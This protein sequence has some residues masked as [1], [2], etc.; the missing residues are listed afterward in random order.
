MPSLL[1]CLIVRQVGATV[2]VYTDDEGSVTL[3]NIAADNRYQI[4]IDEQK[5]IIKEIIPVT[6][7]VAVQK[8]P[9]RHERKIKYN[10]IVDNAA[11]AYG[12]DS[13]LLHAVI[14]VES[15]YN[16]KAVSKKG[17]I[18]LMQLMPETAHRY[19][20]TDSFDPTQNI[21]GGAMYLRDLLKLFNKD[22]RLALAAYNAGESMVVKYGNRIPPIRE[23]REYVPKVLGFYR[24]YQITP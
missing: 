12:L 7:L 2:Y 22:V 8:T 10:Q 17:A 21:N 11:H 16:S 24:K 15:R 1:G 13:A 5:E 20:V 23:T 19:G 4:L 14:S 9:V 3:S 6:T 18:G